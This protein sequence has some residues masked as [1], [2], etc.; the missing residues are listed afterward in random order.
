LDAVR[1]L[2]FD[3]PTWGD[4][5]SRSPM[6]TRVMPHPMRF[7]DESSR[8]I[9]VVDLRP[10]IVSEFKWGIWASHT[11]TRRTRTKQ[12]K[13]YKARGMLPTRRRSYGFEF[14]SP[15]GHGGHI[16]L[17]GEDPAGLS[18]HV[19]AAT[20]RIGWAVGSRTPVRIQA[21]PGWRSPP[22]PVNR[23]SS[24][25][26]TIPQSPVSPASHDATKAFPFLRMTH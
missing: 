11:P 10:C 15:T 4:D 5:V 18:T 3:W 14:W 6:L 23:S 2:R 17:Q 25:R 16:N 20:D 21:P 13:D 8:N 19:L 22:S 9:A 26:R 1:R 7:M 24:R 12:A